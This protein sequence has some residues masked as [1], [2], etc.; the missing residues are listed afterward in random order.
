[1]LQEFCYVDPDQKSLEKRL[2]NY[3]LLKIDH[4]TELATEDK[5]SATT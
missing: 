3:F 5:I 4:Y 2:S 1:M